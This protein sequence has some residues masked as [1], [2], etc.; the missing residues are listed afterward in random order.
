MKHFTKG[1]IAAAGV[2]ATFAAVSVATAAPA[3][4]AQSD[5]PSSNF[6]M[7][8]DAYFGGARYGNANSSSY[9][10]DSWN[11]SATSLYN[12]GTSGMTV[13]VYFNQNYTGLEKI[14]AKGDASNALQFEYPAFPT[15]WN[16]AITSFR[17][18]W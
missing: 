18:L 16:D 3:S 15:S 5:C 12:R 6:C 1:M 10:G 17:W 11:D 14:V 4:A 8:K 13:H 9:V 7:W 2:V